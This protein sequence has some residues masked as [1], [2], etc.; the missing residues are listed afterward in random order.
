MSKK[1][2]KKIHDCTKKYHLE[3]IKYTILLIPS[4]AMS[5]SRMFQNINGINY[6]KVYPTKEKDKTLAKKYFEAKQKAG[7]K[8]FL[9]PAEQ[10]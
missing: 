10:F 3:K 4:V 2:Q 5:S 9:R 7:Q 8:M 6:S 1:L